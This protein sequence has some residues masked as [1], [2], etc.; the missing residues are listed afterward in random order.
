MTHVNQYIC[1]EIWI[2]ITV[3]IAT[4]QR[5]NCYHAS[6]YIS[7]RDAT[8]IHENFVSF[9]R[10]CRILNIEE[11]EDTIE[12]ERERMGRGKWARGTGNETYAP[13]G[14]EVQARYTV[15]AEIFIDLGCGNYGPQNEAVLVCIPGHAG[16]LSV[17]MN[18]PSLLCGHRSTSFPRVP[19][20]KKSRGRCAHSRPLLF[21]YGKQGNSRRRKNIAVPRAFDR[22]FGE[23]VSG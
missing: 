17:R 19:A 10:L 15:Y 21:V 23:R 3:N 16:N 4:M 12:R 1:L 18:A 8:S 22:K 9:H 5:C 11:A 20:W 6:W 7:T 14:V 13:S 2:N